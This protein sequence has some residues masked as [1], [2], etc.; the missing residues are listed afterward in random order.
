[1]FLVNDKWISDE[2]LVGNSLS[3]NHFCGELFGMN[4]LR[5]IL[6]DRE[7]LMWCFICQL[8]G[9]CSEFIYFRHQKYG[10]L[11]AGNSFSFQFVSLW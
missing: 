3:L 5:N 6:F 8:L 11:F 10:E 2:L 4:D 1:M 9:H 7:L